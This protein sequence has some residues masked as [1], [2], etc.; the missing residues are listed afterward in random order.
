VHLNSGLA[1]KK[2]K[3]HCLNFG[4]KRAKIL[5]QLP[6]GGNTVKSGK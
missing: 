3:A 2:L 1:A 4:A 5:G 6:T